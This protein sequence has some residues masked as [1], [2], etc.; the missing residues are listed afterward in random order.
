MVPRIM[1]DYKDDFLGYPEQQ[2]PAGFTRD[3]TWRIFRI[4]AEFIDSFETMSRFKR[5]V[6]VFGSARI[7]PDDPI[8]QDCVHLG[9][10][11]AK[12]HYGVLSGG[13]PGI[14][15]AAN[16]GAWREKGVSV[17]LNIR[18]PMEQSPNRY[19]SESLSF[20]YFFIRKVCFL[21]YSVA[22]VAYPGGFG[23]LDEL[24]EVLTMIQTHKVGRIPLVLVGR[25]FFSPFLD[26]L[27][28][29]LIPMNMISQDD[30]DILHICD[31]AQEA[32]EYIVKWHA[33]YGMPSTIRMDI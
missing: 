21:K 24:C 28:N 17:G 2:Q 7:K 23:T 4:M 18:L 10:L 19:Q 9:E 31:N 25:D 3:E 16:R 5:L 33:T 11:L 15:E 30:L 27:K 1:A 22:A 20:R 29:R 13:G 12:S 14:M 6:T 26:W 32:C 8:Y